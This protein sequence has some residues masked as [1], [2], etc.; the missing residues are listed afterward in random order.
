MLGEMKRELQEAQCAST[1]LMIRPSR[2]FSNPE[3][4]ASNHFQRQTDEAVDELQRSALREFDTLAE[5]LSGLG[6]RVIVFD[7]NPAGP[8]KPDAIYP[9]NWVSFHA[10]GS[11]VLYPMMAPNRRAERRM[12]IIHALQNEYGFCVRE[13]VDLSMHEQEDLFLEGT[14][15][16]VLDRK[17]KVAYACLSPRTN[18]KVLK[19]FVRKLSY[20]LIAFEAHDSR[21]LPIYH[22]NVMMS[23]GEHL[24]VICAESIS[25]SVERDIVLKRLEQ[26]GHSLVLLNSSQINAFAGNMLELSLGS[27]DVSQRLFAMSAQAWTCLNEEQRRV[28]Q[29]NGQV[30]NVP[31]PQ[32]ETNGGG[33][34]R[35]MLAEIH[36]P[37]KG[38]I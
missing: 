16:V 10:D 24:C 2:F 17:N 27:G 30:L 37:K 33:S 25:N 3:T 28:I 36:L 22:T 29:N 38:Q 5:S 1:V 31:I 21:G 35:C 9:N 11:V 15:S 34:V 26:T 12:D 14:G 6:I 8:Q 18:I 19:D 7:D 4:S 32:I 20:E 23:V 13:I